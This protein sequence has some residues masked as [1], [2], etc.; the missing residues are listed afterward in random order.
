MV[1]YIN[2]IG[3]HNIDIFF[4]MVKQVT[5]GSFF[6]GKLAEITHDFFWLNLVSLEFIFVRVTF[7]AIIDI[8][9]YHLLSE[10]LLGV[11]KFNL[12]LWCTPV[13]GKTFHTECFRLHK[14]LFHLSSVHCLCIDITINMVS[15]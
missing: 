11:L 8:Q 12:L 1:H 15:S 4:R 3:K 7:F 2:I 13:E 10:S 9:V 6:F 14:C 5:I